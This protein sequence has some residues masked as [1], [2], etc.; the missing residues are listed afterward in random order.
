MVYNGY[1]KVMSNIPKMGHLPTHVFLMAIRRSIHQS[2]AKQ[3][4]REVQ[5]AHTTGSALHIRRHLRD[6]NGE[7]NVWSVGIMGIGSEIPKNWVTE[8]VNITPIT[9]GIMVVL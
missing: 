9:V 4:W 5:T 7:R 3:Q 2:S 6:G 8:L 1:Y